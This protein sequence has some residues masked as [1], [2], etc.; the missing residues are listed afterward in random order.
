MAVAFL[1][2][3]PSAPSGGHAYNASVCAHWPGTPPDVVQLDGPWPRGDE[4]SRAALRDALARPDV[5]VV[6]GLVGAAHPDLLEEA[7]G[8]GCRTVLLVHLPLADE[9]GLST[10]GRR[11][12][13][14]R[15]RR[16]VRAARRVV[17]TSHTA[18]AGLRR[19]TGRDDI[20]AVPPGV[21]RAALADPHDPPVLLQVGS[22][23]SRKNQL[24]TLA[25]LAG[26][27]DLS[28]RAVFVG[29]VADD[30][31]AERFR[32]A[33]SP[34]RATWTGAPEGPD[35]EAAYAGS[36]LLL[37]PARAETWGM[38]VTEALAHGIPAIVG[39]GTGAV[40]ALTSGSASGLPGAVVQPDDTAGLTAA[41]RSW[42]GDPEL[43]ARWRGRA[44]TARAGLRDWHT[45]A[46]E[47]ARVLELG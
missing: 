25:A 45:A 6:D 16:S 22:I 17:T 27:L 18:A 19:R 34:A 15:E 32:A 36:D 13:E 39:I 35:L 2:P 7:A 11:D 42:L 5:A 47:L 4:E 1:V 29:P 26:R 21:D 20:V 46:A 28:W 41:L 40:E 43:R 8:R 30:G 9:G 44:R 14:R 37:H 3:R 23:G 12:L 24:T 10:A 31:Y 38:V 33:L